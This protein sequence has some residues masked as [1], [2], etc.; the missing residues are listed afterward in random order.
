MPTTPVALPNCLIRKHKP[1]NGREGGRKRRDD[2]G[3]LRETDRPDGFGEIEV[4]R[5]VENKSRK[6]K[7]RRRR[8]EEEQ[9]EED[10][11]SVQTL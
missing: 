1:G 5:H 11:K 9:E 10:K 3:Q 7:G 6:K 4:R 8:E 2:E